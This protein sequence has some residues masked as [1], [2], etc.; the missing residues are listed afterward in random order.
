M[1]NAKYYIQ[2]KDKQIPVIV[3]NYKSMNHV[4]MFFQGNVLNISKPLYLGK[5]EMTKIIKQHEEELYQ[6]YTEILSVNND[7]IKHWQNGEKMLYQGEH[8]LIRR[9][10]CKQNSIKIALEKEKKLVKI[11][12]PDTL[13]EEEVKEIVDKGI[14]NILKQNTE[15]IL[16]QRLHYWSQKMQIPYHSFKVRDTISK[17]GS[18][19]PATKQLYFNA[20]LAMLSQEKIDAIIVHELCHIIH[21]NHS[22]EFYN[23]VKSYIPNYKEIDQWLKQHNKELA[24]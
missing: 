18:C 11:S 21:R 16:Q 2:I 3:R 6:H 8:F 13:K 12:L 19:K 1:A 22:Q 10:Y 5:G 23:L 14:K 20:R 15:C 9:E 7:T 24:I 4:K 17:F